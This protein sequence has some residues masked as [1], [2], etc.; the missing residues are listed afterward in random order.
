MGLILTYTLPWAIST[1]ALA[2][3]AAWSWYLFSAALAL[4][5]S[6]ALLAGLGPLGDREVWR[7]LFLL[8][9]RDLAAPILWGAAFAGR[10]VVWR[11]ERFAVK[12]GRLEKPAGPS[13]QS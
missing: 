10:E 5:L 4:R 7:S 1:V 11:G 13:R 12:A 6:G 8:P 9:V 3:G 2:R